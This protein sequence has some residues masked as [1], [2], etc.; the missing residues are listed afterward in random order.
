MPKNN[1]TKQITLDVIMDAYR[2]Y[3]S[4]LQQVRKIQRSFCQEM[5]FTMTPQLDDLEAEITYLLLRVY[6]P[7]HVVELGALH[8]WSTTWILH[9]LHDNEMGHLYSYDLIDR[10]ARNVPAELATDRWTFIQ[11]DMRKN[12]GRLPETVDYLF[13]DADHSGR[14]AKWY[15][16]ELFPLVP[17]GTPTSVHDVFHYKHALPFSEGRVVLQWLASTQTSYITAAPAKA[18]D[19]RAK[20]LALKKELSLDEPV[21]KSLDNPMI[22]FNLPKT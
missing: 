14:F 5:R 11:G 19:V 21:R 8:G 18:P 15:I 13:V 17:A 4:D 10:A 1:V 3:A 12:L 16:K 2:T 7:K 9:A 6:R 22:F 20:L